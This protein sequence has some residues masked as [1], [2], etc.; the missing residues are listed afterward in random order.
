MKASLIQRHFN[1]KAKADKALS[2]L[3]VKA[4]TIGGIGSRHKILMRYP[5][6]ALKALV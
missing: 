5:Y 3:G 6:K 1:T 4:P 2:A